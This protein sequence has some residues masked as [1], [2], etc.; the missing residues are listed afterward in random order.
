[1]DAQKRRIR[2][3]RRLEDRQEIV[4]APLPVLITVVR[5]LNR[6][7]YPTVPARLAA[8]K[9]ELTIW[10]NRVLRLDTEQIGFKGSPTVVKR[11]F[12]PEQKPGEVLGD[13]LR[14][15]QAAVDLLMR[16]LRERELLQSP[17]D[18]TGGRS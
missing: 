3:R 2:V 4:E 7:R 11:I 1:F 12:S 5:E 15:P 13:G 6:P 16:R 9:A 10:D 17:F 8:E 14:D 18:G